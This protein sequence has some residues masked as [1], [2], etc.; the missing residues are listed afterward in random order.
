MSSSCT[1]GR[2]SESI[3]SLGERTLLSNPPVQDP[4]PIWVCC[5]PRPGGQG[6]IHGV[7]WERECV[8]A[9]APAGL[10]GCRLVVSPMCAYSRRS[11]ELLQPCRVP[12][13][14]ELKEVLAR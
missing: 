12:P 11:S 6:G 1:P 10:G 8:K 3:A 2:D 13:S 5:W 14:K 7:V 9:T 4:E